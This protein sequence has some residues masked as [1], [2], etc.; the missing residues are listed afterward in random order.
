VNICMLNLSH[1]GMDDNKLSEYLRDA[2]ASSIL[3]LE[4]V[5]AV[6]VER[7]VAGAAEGKGGKSSVSISFSG[8]LNAIDGV[9]SQEGRIFFMTTNHI[10][11]LDPAL[12]RPG[13]CDVKVELKHASRQQILQM[14]LRFFP[15]ENRLGEVFASRLP[16]NELSMAA[17][18]GHFLETHQTAQSCVDNIPALLLTTRPE[19]AI[20]ESLHCHLRRVG[21]EQYT[22]VLEAIGI[23]LA[24]EFS[25]AQ[26]TLA[27]LLKMSL[28]LQYDTPAQKV[29]TQLL[30]SYKNPNSADSL[31][32][33]ANEYALADMSALR[34]AFMAAYA[35]APD[36]SSSSSA[37]LGH[38]DIDALCREFCECL[39]SEGK[40][41]ISLHSLRRLLAMCPR[42]PLECLKAAP[43][44]TAPRASR[45]RERAFRTMT[46]Y[47]FLKRAAVGEHIHN[48]EQCA[49]LDALVNIDKSTVADMTAALKPYS[50]QP[51]DASNLAEILTKTV[52]TRG[53][54]HRFN[55]PTRK[56]LMDVF[57]SFYTNASLSSSLR[58][59]VSG[60]NDVAQE[61]E[62][63]VEQEA[64]IFGTLLTD[65]RGNGL[66]SLLEVEKHLARHP[67]DAAA[68][69][70]SALQELLD[71]PLPAAPPAPQDAPEPT[72]W[73]YTWLKRGET[74]CDTH[75]K[76]IVSSLVA[77]SAPD[78]AA[79][80]VMSIEKRKDED[81]SSS[82]SSSTEREEKKDTGEEKK[83]EEGGGGLEQ[84][85]AQFIQ[86]HMCTQH[87]LSAHP[88]LT[89]AV[90]EKTLGVSKLGHRRRIIR[91]QAQ[92]AGAVLD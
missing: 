38:G 78:K 15:G 42:R 76:K 10:E 14:F 26:L 39:S 89:D 71:P 63:E 24:S 20:Q 17:L 68:A 81:S 25:S 13:R 92:L 35:G 77:D 73:V 12:V 59:N 48:F 29:F 5:D 58:G 50:L 9:A 87:D 16:A 84:Y 32:F 55:L 67:A 61:R 51:E 44:F 91:M 64:F 54:M 23:E 47:T 11:K 2:P 88:P 90:L 82:S 53:A 49:N 75:Q 60:S 37:L 56:R 52:T 62:E 79:C 18:Q 69:R 80:I 70:A 1:A 40:G 27:E 30:E 34:E 7:G 57:V 85:A 31:T 65:E 41:L 22:P 8:L 21:L 4:N 86:E 19:V 45:D 74:P 6:F 72:E 83:E 36:A 66:V 33:L 46:L 3:V 43:A 28:E